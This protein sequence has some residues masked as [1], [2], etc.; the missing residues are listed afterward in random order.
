M[1]RIDLHLHSTFSDGSMTPEALVA[2][3]RSKGLSVMCLT[4]HDTL[5]G[6]PSFLA[7][8]SRWN[9]AGLSGIELAADH[10][11]TVHILGYR[12][13]MRRTGMT[14]VLEKLR[15]GRLARNAE[16]C[17][18]LRK[19]SVDISLEEVSL[20]A[21]GDVIA[22]P[23][24]ARVL[25]KKGYSPDIP[26]AFSRY[27]NSASPAYVERYRL[28]AAECIRLISDAGGLA[29]LAHP[30]QTSENLTELRKIVKEL[31]NYG[32]WGIE[33]LSSRTPAWRIFQ[34]LSLAADFGLF[35]TAGNDFHGN[36]R[37]S[38]PMGIVVTEDF[39]PWARLG[40]SL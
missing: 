4:D 17:A 26:S 7:A 23:H 31:K 20:E 19:M 32:L 22:R 29:V 35:P 3:G 12:L 27:L 28:S 5:D 33:C 11:R 25:V 40:I 2:H 38:A 15:E 1:L 36:N 21:S 37:T 16:M 24:M 13:D 6:I 8:C 39:L 18:K 14:A 30:A 34:Y 9:I 10:V